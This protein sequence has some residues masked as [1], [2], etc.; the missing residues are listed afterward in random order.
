MGLVG[1]SGSFLPA[2]PHVTARPMVIVMLLGVALTACSE[3][4]NGSDG[5]VA[6][7]PARPPNGDTHIVELHGQLTYPV[8]R[9][10][11]GRVAANSVVTALVEY[12]RAVDLAN[13]FPLI[14]GYERAA[15]QSM[16]GNALSDFRRAHHDLIRDG[17]AARGR[18]TM[19]PVVLNIQSTSA[20]A[21]NCWIPDGVTMYFRGTGKPASTPDGGV[22]LFE[23]LLKRIDGKWL[24]VGVPLIEQGDAC[25]QSDATS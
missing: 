19:N 9:V 18:T 21:I 22:A 7:D 10:K 4:L 12:Q 23:Y 13:T 8:E 5:G 1:R 3:G 17:L 25:P 16:S 6:R 2:S 24:V 14:A 15:E 20:T 11:V